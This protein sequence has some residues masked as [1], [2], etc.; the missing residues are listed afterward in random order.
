MQFIDFPRSVDGLRQQRRPRVS[1]GGSCV[2]RRDPKGFCFYLFSAVHANSF[3][4]KRFLARAGEMNRSYRCAMIAIRET[5]WWSGGCYT[6]FGINNRRTTR[7]KSHTFYKTNK[8]FCNEKRTQLTCKLWLAVFFS[9][10]TPPT[11]TSF[12]SVYF[13]D[14]RIIAFVLWKR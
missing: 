13:Y 12:F 10:H 5:D 1:S 14:F 7:R 9:V 3:Q 2:G 11:G 6:V 8:T 4:G